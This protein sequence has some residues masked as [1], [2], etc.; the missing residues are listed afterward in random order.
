M[1][2][3][4]A[5]WMGKNGRVVHVAG[6][7]ARSQEPGGGPGG[8]RERTMH[9]LPEIL[10]PADLELPGGRKAQRR[11]M[12]LR[13]PLPCVHHRGQELGALG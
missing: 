2:E 11:W 7:G 12:I 13:L 3:N 5:V 4:M 8:R 9:L 6:A 1:A 10:G